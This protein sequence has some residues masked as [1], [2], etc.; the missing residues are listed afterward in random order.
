[1]IK[2]KEFQKKVKKILTFFFLF[3]ILQEFSKKSDKKTT[4]FK[5]LKKNKKKY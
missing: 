3:D 5:F 1:M 2:K 4:K